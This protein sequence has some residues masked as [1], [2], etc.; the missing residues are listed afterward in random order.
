MRLKAAEL[1]LPSRETAFFACH[2]GG[3]TRHSRVWHVESDALAA[4]LCTTPVKV[5]SDRSVDMAPRSSFLV[6]VSTLYHL[7]NITL[8][9]LQ[10]LV[11][12]CRHVYPLQRRALLP[13]S[14]DTLR[15]QESKDW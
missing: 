5:R 7:S 12:T 8:L 11:N 10:V 6:V 15:Y 13:W 9:Y 3:S 2:Q 14:A 1:S 4:R